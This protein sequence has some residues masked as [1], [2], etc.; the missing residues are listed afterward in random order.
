MGGHCSEVGAHCS[1][2]A[3]QWGLY[4]NGGCPHCSG[5]VLRW[6]CIAMGVHC[7]RGWYAIG[8]HSSGGC[9]AMGAATVPAVAALRWAGPR[10]CHRAGYRGD[11]MCLDHSGDACA[12]GRSGLVPAG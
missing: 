12:E 5:G 11:L 8:M 4:C 10:G 6:G 9:P 2:G 1:R 3:L 7:S